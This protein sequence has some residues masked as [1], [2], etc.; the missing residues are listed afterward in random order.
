[1]S[2]KSFDSRLAQFLVR[3][4]VNTGLHPNHLTT[5]SLGVGLAG[6]ACFIE[7]SRCGIS[8]GA[9]LYIL[10]M[11]LDHADGELA[12]LSGKASAFG[13]R[14]DRAVD[15]IVKSAVFTGMGI[16]V[17][18]MSASLW[19]VLMGIACGTAFVGIFLGHDAIA[20]RTRTGLPEQPA[21][22]GFEIEDV[23]YLIGPVVWLGWLEEFLGVTSV[24][25][26]AYAFF[27]FLKW[28]R[29]GRALPTP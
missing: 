17:A 6:A 4:F 11:F 25:A 26:P 24:G 9:G 22:G 18:R 8:I 27:V 21:S 29:L 7:G 1:M 23:L 12:R 10:A 2:A 16:G 15:L 20:A 3:P 13:Q 5:A 14:Y 19:P 28:R